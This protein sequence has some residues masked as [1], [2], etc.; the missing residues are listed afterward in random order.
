MPSATSVGHYSA[1]CYTGQISTV[2]EDTE[3]TFLGAIELDSDKQW[4]STLVLNKTEVVF[5]LDTRAEAT[6]ISTET[7][8]ELRNVTLHEP[9][10]ILRGPADNQL[11]VIGQ[12]TGSLT[13][14]Q[15]N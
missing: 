4:L 13:Y 2:T 7:H 1:C 3:N 15:A 12:F 5:K 6:A 9:T 14:K 11:F 10:K 8:H